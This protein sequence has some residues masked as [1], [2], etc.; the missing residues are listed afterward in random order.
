MATYD[1]IDVVDLHGNANRRERT[2]KGKADKN[3]FDIRQGVAV[4]ILTRCSRTPGCTIRHTDCWSE[5]VAG[6][7]AWLAKTPYTSV[8]WTHVEPTGQPFHRFLP[9]E[10]VDDAYLQSLSVCD[11]FP[12]HSS[13]IITSRDRLLVAVSREVLCAR[14]TK[15]L[16][17]AVPD[18][19]FRGNYGVRDNYAWSLRDARQKLRESVDA[20]NLETWCSPL[21]Y[22]PLQKLWVFYH[23]ALVWRP[24]K[25]VMAHLQH[26]DRPALVTVRQLSR[27]GLEWRHA[28]V[29]HG[30]VEA[31]Y[32]SNR[33]RE[34]NYVFPL[35]LNDSK[36]NISPSAWK[37]FGTWVGTDRSPGAARSIFDY[38]V[39]LLHSDRYR[40][41]Y[42]GALA[43]DYPRVPA[44]SRREDFEALVAA[45]RRLRRLDLA[46]AQRTLEYN[47]SGKTNAPRPLRLVQKARIPTE[48]CD[49]A[50]RRLCVLKTWMGRFGEASQEKS[51]PLGALGRAERIRLHPN[52]CTVAMM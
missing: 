8:S 46:Y 36:P 40:E 24:R 27:H 13:G 1:H 11:I 9:G 2:P 32:L 31:C 16:D 41:T 33:T 35:F 38:V 20:S 42:R 34:I 28:A 52:E 19:W 51:G 23:P 49:T 18:S 15:L 47:H 25:R 4:S 12:V 29:T 48:D 10:V 5:T 39:G 26:Q 7:K 3:V 21:N 43:I 22:R 17:P 50:S 44:P 45:G 30:L 6:K 14:V 37:V